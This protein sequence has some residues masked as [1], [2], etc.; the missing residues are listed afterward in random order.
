MAPAGAP[1]VTGTAPPSTTC[2]VTWVTWAVTCTVPVSPQGR[3]TVGCAGHGVLGGRV[4]HPRHPLS[5]LQ[6]CPPCPAA[7]STLTA[8]NAVEANKLSNNYNVGGCGMGGGTHRCSWMAVIR[9][10]FLPAT[11]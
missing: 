10:L 9:F 7:C 8:E 1:S 11:L 5:R 4:L 3:S 2:R 6:L